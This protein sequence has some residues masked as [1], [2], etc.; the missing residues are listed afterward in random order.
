MIELSHGNGG[1]TFENF[2][3]KTLMPLFDNPILKNK[4]DGALLKEIKGRIVMATDSHV[5]SPRIFPGGSLGKLAFCGTVNDLAMMGAK[6]LYL[7]LSLIIEEGFDLGELELHLAHIAEL[8]KKYHI[9]I[10][11][12][13]TKVVE[14]NKADGL[15]ITTTGIGS[16]KDTVNLNSKFISE[17]DQIILN[18]PI[19]DHAMAIFSKRENIDFESDILSD[20]APLHEMVLGLLDQYPEIKCLRDPTRGGI[21]SALNELASDSNHTLGIYEDKVLLNPSVKAACELFGFDPFE[22]ANEGKFLLF[23]PKNISSDICH[24]LNTHW[25]Q[26]A[27]IIGAVKASGD[28]LVE[29]ETLL[30]ARIVPWPSH[31]Q[32]PRIC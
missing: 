26:R 15:F 10:V 30:G 2:F 14:R 21:S 29:C 9:P 7:S 27:Q 12:G 25:N 3:N 11:T 17:G 24:Y 8:S 5:A 23:A 32:L 19:G 6:P 31:E 16:V 18:G 20:C 22:L 13:D 4:A 1:K 28:P